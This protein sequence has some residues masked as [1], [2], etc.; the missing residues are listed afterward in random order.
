MNYFLRNFDPSLST[1]S[2]MVQSA[3]DSQ[4]TS[5]NSDT[6]SNTSIYRRKHERNWWQR[7]YTKLLFHYANENCVNGGLINC[8]NNDEEA[9]EMAELTLTDAMKYCS[10]VARPSSFGAEMLAKTM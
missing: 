8:V 9:S 4:S 7:Q 6:G 3:S 1:T 2:S 5:Q 10:V